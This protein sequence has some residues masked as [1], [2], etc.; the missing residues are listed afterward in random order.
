MNA[1]PPR[2]H[3]SDAVLSRRY[4]EVRARTL[5]LA[6]P[7]SEA[8]CQVQSMLD[9]SPI[10][11]HLAHTTWFFEPFVLEGH[12]RNFRPHHRLARDLE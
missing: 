12:E 11:W 4:A 3:E 5:A 10:K 7:L 9:A 6:A 1:A 2:L 8:D